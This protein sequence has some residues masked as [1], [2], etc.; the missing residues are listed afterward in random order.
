MTTLFGLPTVSSY[1]IVTFPIWNYIKAGLQQNLNTAIEYYR[2][3]PL[4]IESSHLLV[5]L[6]YSLGISKTEPIESFYN[7]LSIK[8]LK[9]AAMCRFTTAISKG[10]IYDGVFY[11]PGNREIVIAHDDDFDPIWAVKNWRNLE[12]IK[13]LSHPFSDLGLHV[14]NGQKSSIEEGVCVIAVNVP[15]LAIQYREFYNL[16]TEI[17]LKTGENPRSIMHFLHAYP[18]NN[19]LRSHLD[20]VLFNRLYNLLGGIPFGVTTRKHAFYQTDFS[21]KLEML[22]AEQLK[23]LSNKVYDFNGVLSSIPVVSSNDLLDLAQIP[24]IAPTRQVVWALILSR[25]RMFSFVARVSNKPAH[26]ANGAVANQI[27][28][29]FQLYNADKVFQTVLPPEM[30]YDARKDMNTIIELMS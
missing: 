10:D 8:S 27:V 29:L 6:L 28:R 12:P 17:S 11:G 9:V 21:Q 26:T 4:R 23:A 20:M 3:Y 7:Y 18:L 13:V 2:Q 14:P 1:G 25:L 30:Y 15:M 22:E 5:K 19:M 16:E 24:D